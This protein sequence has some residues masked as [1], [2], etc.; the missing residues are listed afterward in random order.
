MNVP[1]LK[2]N[3]ATEYV[4]WIPQMDAYSVY[5]EFSEVMKATKYAKLPYNEKEF[6]SDDDET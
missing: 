2:T 6:K 4:R 3:S 5:K 1:M